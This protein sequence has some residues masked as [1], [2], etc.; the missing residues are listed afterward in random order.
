MKREVVHHWTNEPGGYSS[1][2]GHQ[3][4]MNIVYGEE[5]GRKH[6]D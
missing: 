1:G 3:K 2:N 6:T 5:I 4:A